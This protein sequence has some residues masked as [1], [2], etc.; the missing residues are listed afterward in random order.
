MVRDACLDK[1]RLWIQ[2]QAQEL[3]IVVHSFN[4]KWEMEE[5]QKF[6]GSGWSHGSVGKSTCSSYSGM[7]S[8]SPSHQAASQSSVTP[9]PGYLMPSSGLQKHYTRV[10]HAQKH[11]H[12]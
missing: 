8:V 2:S 6:R 3:S 10:A 4:G 1:L 12:T 7:G 9:V 11:A 5:D